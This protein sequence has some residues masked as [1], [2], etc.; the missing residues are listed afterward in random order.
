MGDSWFFL[1]ADNFSVQVD[2]TAG[3][4]QA[5]PQTALRLQAAVLEEVIEGTQLMKVGDEPQLGAGI[6]GCHVRGYETYRQNR[7]WLI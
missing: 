3:H 7:T 6:L 5:H 1:R 2:Q 4:R